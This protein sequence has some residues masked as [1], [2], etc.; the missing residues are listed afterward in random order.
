[1]TRSI[2]L[3]RHGVVGFSTSL[4]NVRSNSPFENLSAILKQKRRFGLSP[5]QTFRI[6]IS[7]ISVVS[8]C[9]R[10]TWWT[11]RFAFRRVI[12]SDHIH[13]FTRSTP[14]HYRIRARAGFATLIRARSRNARIRRVARRPYSPCWSSSSSFFRFFVDL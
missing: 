5:P 7:I 13:L 14:L 11:T 10:R 6:I 1:M 4:S 8:T 2:D 9:F 3:G 12:S